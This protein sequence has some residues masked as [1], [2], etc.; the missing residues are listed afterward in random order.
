LEDQWT[1]QRQAYRS[2]RVLSAALR[3]KSLNC[4]QRNFTERANLTT[5][6]SVYQPIIH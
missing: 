3:W 2:R 5:G 4:S 1:T 6:I